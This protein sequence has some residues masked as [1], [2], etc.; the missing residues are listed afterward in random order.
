LRANGLVVVDEVFSSVARMIVNR[1][2][3]QLKADAIMPLIDSLKAVT[4]EGA[5]AND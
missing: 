1:A 3:Y 5:K 2:S 4:C